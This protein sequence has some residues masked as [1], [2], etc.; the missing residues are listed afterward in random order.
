MMMFIYI[1]G[2]IFQ[3]KII[4]TK[5]TRNKV[6]YAA[7]VC[8]TLPTGSKDTGLRNFGPKKFQ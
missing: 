4:E 3:L 8:Q 5:R 6:N 2:S 7:K 1:S